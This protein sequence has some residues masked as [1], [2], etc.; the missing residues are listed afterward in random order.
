MSELAPLDEASK[1]GKKTKRRLN[2]N[3]PMG[4]TGS[5]VATFLTSL[6]LLLLKPELGLGRFLRH[7]FSLAI[8]LRSYSLYLW[9][10]PVI[11]LDRWTVGVSMASLLPILGLTALLT[12]FSYQLETLFR[13]SR[14]AK[15][16]VRRPTDP[17]AVAQQ[18]HRPGPSPLLIYPFFTLASAGL[19]VGLQGP[20]KTLLFTGRRDVPLNGTSNMKEITGTPINTSNCFQEP[21]AG[22]RTDRQRDKCRLIR[23]PGKP[24]LYF[25]GDSHTNSI[26]PLGEDI[27]K[28][29]NFNVSF[30]ARGAA[31]SPI[32]HP[33]PSICYQDPAINFA[34][35]A[36][37]KS[38][39]FFKT[40][41]KLGIA[42]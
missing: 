8:G 32:S 28:N 27:L 25:I 37:Q 17:G 1:R 10:W 12:L 35:K 24:T 15:T 14:K 40:R 33:K 21:T 19:L 9:H 13:S 20:F 11:V 36:V 42:L 34:P 7:P 41:S 16:P 38:G 5:I 6:L 26:I 29:T 22:P 39:N 2:F 23:D 31:P 4:P 30:V 3:Q 18:P